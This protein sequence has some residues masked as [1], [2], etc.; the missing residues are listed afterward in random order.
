ME[1][2]NVMR[3]MD[4]RPI[5]AI[6]L[7]AGCAVG[8]FEGVAGA[9]TPGDLDA[10]F[11]TAGIA[12]LS[13][14]VGYDDVRGVTLQ[15]D[16]KI[17]AVGSARDGANS[18]IVVARYNADGSLDTGFDGNSGVSNGVVVTGVSGSDF[19]RAVAIQADGKIVAAGQGAGDFLAPEIVLV[20]YNSDGT[21][22]T[23]F[24]ADGI[25][26]TQPNS[27]SYLAN[28]IALQG[29]GKIIVAGRGGAGFT[30]GDFAVVRYNIDG[31]LDTTF[32]ADGVV[33]TAIGG[34]TENAYAVAVQADGKVV[35]AGT[36]SIQGNQFVVVR[37]ASDGS[38][39]TTFSTDGIVTTAVGDGPAAETRALVIQ[40][41]GKIL[42]GGYNDTSFA[43]S[44]DYVLLRY[45]TDGTLD[46][47]FSTDGI[48]VSNVKGREDYLH[49]LALQGDGDIVAAGSIETSSGDYD[50]GVVRYNADGTTDTFATTPVASDYDFAYATA[51]QPD[52]TI[53][54]AG[55]SHNGIETSGDIAVTRYAST[56]GDGLAP[57]GVT[58]SGDGVSTGFRLL[59][60]MPLSWEAVDDRGVASYDVRYRRAPRSAG[61]GSYVT[62]RNDTTLTSGTLTAAAGYTY[63]I[64][65]TASDAQL[66]TSA[67]TAQRCTAIP[68]NNTSLSHHGSWSKRTASGYYLNTYSTSSTADAY[69]TL[70]VAA[71]ELSLVATK[72]SGCGTVD[73]Y[74]GSTKL[75]RIYLSAATT[76]K[77][78]LIPIKT[79]TSLKTG[80]VKI[81]IVSSRKPVRIEGLAT[82]RL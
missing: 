37:Y 19:A 11:G 26:T 82:S 25:V 3:F 48:V 24:D 81:K 14:G 17:V 18:Q 74:F 44:F 73:V 42:A 64:S 66:N 23:T 50:F 4:V 55:G 1:K 78:R 6:V 72:C 36:G 8:G 2:A 69:L 5:V 35:V 39:D 21:L 65:A 62:W 60:A 41:D 79:F 75:R 15:A 31:T 59:A 52:G 70:G 68:V 40:A 9:G 43:T 12:T 47:S 28:A 63:C 80:T 76:S 45:N 58:L 61:F 13:V 49:A 7:A 22:D 53:L 32:S 10:A 29:D 20:R 54:A 33:T 16:G 77:Q 27:G 56:L 57:T 38:L 30:G 46:T 51:I 71:K 34:G 67:W